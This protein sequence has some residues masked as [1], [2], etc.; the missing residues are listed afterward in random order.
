MGRKA[1]VVVA[2]AKVRAV[3]VT[4]AGWGRSGG[5]LGSEMGDFSD[6]IVNVCRRETHVV[7]EIRF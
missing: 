6:N 1:N 4:V 3:G 5:V 2:R 7:T